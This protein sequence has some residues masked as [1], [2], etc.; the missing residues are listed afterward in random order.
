M[1]KTFRK[2]KTISKQRQR[3]NKKGG[4]KRFHFEE[5]EY[6]PR[7]DDKING[8]KRDNDAEE[9]HPSQELH[10]QRPSEPTDQTDHG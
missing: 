3:L 10:K 9:I 6:D 5:Y 4:Q 1:G 8:V 7:A 2:E